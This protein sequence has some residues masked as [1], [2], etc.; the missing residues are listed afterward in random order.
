M[1]RDTND[2]RGIPFAVII[3]LQTIV[4]EIPTPSVVF[5]CMVTVLAEPDTIR[6]ALR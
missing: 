3:V 4:A 5:P 1:V 6:V 2:G